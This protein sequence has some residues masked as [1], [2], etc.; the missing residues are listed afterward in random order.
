[1]T[2]RTLDAIHLE[3]AIALHQ[4]GEI[5]AVLSYDDQLRAGCAHHVIRVDAPVVR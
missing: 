4:S 5:E 3:A 1:M 2:V